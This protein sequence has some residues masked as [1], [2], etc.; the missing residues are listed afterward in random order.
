M[1][2]V[3]IT[4]FGEDAPVASVYPSPQGYFAAIDFGDL[5]TIN[6][7]GYDAACALHARAVAAELFRAAKEIEAACGLTHPDDLFPVED[8]GGKVGA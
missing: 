2:Y 3:S 1:A 6:L 8:D 4:L 5:I 7:R